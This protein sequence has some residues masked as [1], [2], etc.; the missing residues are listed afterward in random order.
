MK[1]CIFFVSITVFFANAE[2]A[3]LPK[4]PACCMPCAAVPAPENKPVSKAI[5][6]VCTQAQTGGSAL[7]RATG[8]MCTAP[9]TLPN[10]GNCQSYAISHS[11]SPDYQITCQLMS[12]DSTIQPYPFCMPSSLGT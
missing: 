6:C 10:G 2:E 9:I 3:A 5:Y 8:R 1:K 7:S 4:N 11:S 12:L